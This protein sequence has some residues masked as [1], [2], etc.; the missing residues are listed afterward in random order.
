MSC[1]YNRSAITPAA[2]R[3]RST[4]SSVAI[5]GI[6]P[7]VGGR[8]SRS[9]ALRG[10]SPCGAVVPAGSRKSTSP[11]S[12]RAA[13]PNWLA[14]SAKDAGRVARQARVLIDH[15]ALRELQEYARPRRFDP[16][17]AGPRLAGWRQSGA[18]RSRFPAC[19]APLSLLLGPAA[20][21]SVLQATPRRKSPDSRVVAAAGWRPSRVS[22]VV[23]S[24]AVKCPPG[25]WSVKVR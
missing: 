14:S 19:L 22:S 25:G 21:V 15:V 1:R 16:V 9:R 18:R 23:N 8:P 3:C 5:P 20:Y 17:C 4:C 6:A 12:V 13:G 2:L 11:S 24:S 10:R 7:G